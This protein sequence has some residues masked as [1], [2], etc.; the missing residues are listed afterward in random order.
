MGA[1]VA[2]RFNRNRNTGTNR[3]L[4]QLGLPTLYG[5]NGVE[6]ANFFET[7]ATDCAKAACGGSR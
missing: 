6:H 1:G 4:A 7:R 5:V 2:V 3:G